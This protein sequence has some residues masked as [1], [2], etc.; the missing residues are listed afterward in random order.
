V[1][2]V[3]ALTSG[4]LRNRYECYSYDHPSASHQHVVICHKS[5]LVF[6][7]GNDDDNYAWEDVAQSTLRPAVHGIL[8]QR[9]GRDLA[10]V[11]ALHLKAMPDQRTRRLEQTRLIASHLAQ[12]GDRLPVVVLGDLNT[13]DDEV[14]AM[15]R[16]YRDHGVQLS[17]VDLMNEFTYRTDR[18]QS[19]FD[20]LLVTG[21]VDVISSG[22]IE[23]PCNDDWTSGTAFDDLAYYNEK[24]SDHCP[25]N[26]V[27][28][29]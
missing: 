18:Y 29:L 1:V 15:V 20:W 9:N 16:I 14:S 28:D 22:R 26:V 27:L 3:P 6:R 17:A 25:V 12:R 23:G 10:H 5:N 13:Y 21:D 7:V 2:D 11:V 4:L 8:A 19:T 24:V